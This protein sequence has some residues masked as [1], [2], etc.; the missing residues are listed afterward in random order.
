MRIYQFGY[1]FILLI[2]NI[3]LAVCYDWIN[4]ANFISRLN[5]LVSLDAQIGEKSPVKTKLSTRISRQRRDVF[6]T[7][8]LAS[9]S[10][11][12]Q[13]IYDHSD[14]LRPDNKFS[15]RI[16]IYEIT[17]KVFSQAATNL[18]S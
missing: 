2:L 13:N 10:I 4:I 11:N 6:G 9:V 8:S 1:Q 15:K 12:S 16:H 17:L 3:Q 18:Y 7:F 5:D 14:I